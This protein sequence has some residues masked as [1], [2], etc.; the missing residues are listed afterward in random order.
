MYRA[1]FARDLVLAPTRV[2]SEHQR[3]HHFVADAAWPDD[4][5]LAAVRDYV[6]EKVVPPAGGPEAL[7]IDDTG[8]PNPNS[9][10]ADYRDGVL[11]IHLTRHESAQPR[12]ITIQ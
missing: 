5:V 1:L 12:R 2:R 10:S 3:L 8:F 9:V 7:L 6:L 4:A 11:H